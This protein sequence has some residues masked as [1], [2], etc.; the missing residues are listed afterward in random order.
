[1]RTKYIVIGAVGA[2]GFVYGAAVAALVAIRRW[3]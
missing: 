3:V 2:V 1:M